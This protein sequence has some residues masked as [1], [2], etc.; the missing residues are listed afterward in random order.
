[1]KPSLKLS[2]KSKLLA[3]VLGAITDR[4]KLDQIEDTRRKAEERF[5]DIDFLLA[6]AGGDGSPEPIEELSEARWDSVLATNLKSKFLTVR[7]FLSGMKRR[8]VGSIILMCSSAG[9]APSQASLAYSSAQAG[10][11]MLARNL[12]QQVG[13]HGIRVM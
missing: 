11:A 1:M 8:G 7:T 2:P 13:G 3:E 6:F 12:A 4:T 5:G 9:R 10:V